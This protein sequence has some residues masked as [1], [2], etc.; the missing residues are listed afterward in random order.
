MHLQIKRNK[1]NEKFFENK[2]LNC[3]L[4][5]INLLFHKRYKIIA[6]KK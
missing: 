1:I 4:N 5:T 3:S 6:E 2:K